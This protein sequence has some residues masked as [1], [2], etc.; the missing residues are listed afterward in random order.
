[1]L[2]LSSAELTAILTILQIY[3][4]YS[5]R[6]P[7]NHYKKN[8]HYCTTIDQ[9][10]STLQHNTYAHTYHKFIKDGTRRISYFSTSPTGIPHLTLLDYNST[11]LTRKL[12]VPLENLPETV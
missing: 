4:L 12:G 9:H 3:P 10:T 7:H 11:Y 5:L 8:L 1:M 6:I 2:I